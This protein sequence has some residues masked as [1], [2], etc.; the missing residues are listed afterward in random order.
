MICLIRL[1]DDTKCTTGALLEP[2]SPQY[3][4]DT[5]TT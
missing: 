1:K 3:A 4:A 2:T 5:D